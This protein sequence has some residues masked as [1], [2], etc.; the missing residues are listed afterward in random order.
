MNHSQH[1]HKHQSKNPTR[2]RAMNRGTPSLSAR[3]S[4]DPRRFSCCSCFA[5][6]RS[7]CFLALASRASS[8]STGTSR[9][10]HGPTPVNHMLLKKCP[11]VIPPVPWEVLSASQQIQA[12][13]TTLMERSLK[14]NSIDFW[15]Y[16]SV[17]QNEKC[18]C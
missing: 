16:S 3:F 11:G 4:D 2:L 15:Q 9:E 5:R 7:S 13:M 17:D 8:S 10:Q 14:K 6:L 12:Q 1:P 18:Y